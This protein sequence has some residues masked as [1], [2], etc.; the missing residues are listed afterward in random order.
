MVQLAVGILQFQF[1]ALSDLEA[2]KTDLSLSLRLFTSS[3]GSARHRDTQARPVH[4]GFGENRERRE[5][6]AVRGV[7]PGFGRGKPSLQNPGLL[8]CGRLML[9]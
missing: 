5:P 1:N 8:E 4:T 6:F 2:R 9:T 7:Q 3:Q